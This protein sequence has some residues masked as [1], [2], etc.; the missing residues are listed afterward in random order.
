MSE[1]ITKEATEATKKKRFNYL[2]DYMTELNNTEPQRFDI[3][4][5][6][7]NTEHKNDD[8]GL[9]MRV[10]GAIPRHT[11][12]AREEWLERYENNEPLNCDTTACVY[13]HFP[14][15]FPKYFEWVTYNESTYIRS[16]DNGSYSCEGAATDISEFL[17]GSIND[18]HRIIM[19]S[20]YGSGNPSLD[21]VIARIEELYHKLYE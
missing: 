12:K 6:M 14:L 9:D 1:T 19:P 2:L 21:I 16:K 10:P 7:I 18:W 5:W 4:S 11:R 13:G 20:S 17:G 3:R 15:A 8:P